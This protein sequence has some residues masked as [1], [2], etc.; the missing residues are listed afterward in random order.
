MIEEIYRTLEYR[1]NAGCIYYVVYYDTYDNAY[2]VVK[3]RNGRNTFCGRA[4]KTRA[5]AIKRAKMLA[6]ALVAE[7]VPE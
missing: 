1:T 2:L 3:Y 6:S 5:G 4:Y 7:S